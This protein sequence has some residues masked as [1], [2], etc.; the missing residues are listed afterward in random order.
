MGRAACRAY[1]SDRIP[2]T[3]PMQHPG[4][5]DRDVPAFLQDVASGSESKPPALQLHRG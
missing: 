5:P 3:V 1:F 4:T 2:N